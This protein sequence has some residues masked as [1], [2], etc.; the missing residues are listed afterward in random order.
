LGCTSPSNCPANQV[1]CLTN[2]PDAGLSQSSCQSSCQNG[3]RVCD[4]QMPMCGGDQCKQSF[5]VSIISTC[6]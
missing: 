4:P 5:K 3:D 1:C 6:N 2:I